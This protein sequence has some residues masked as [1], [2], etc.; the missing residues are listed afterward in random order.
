LSFKK[1]AQ[2]FALCSARSR[3]AAHSLARIA[4]VTSRPLSVFASQ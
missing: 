4:T 3:Q 2:P 1:N